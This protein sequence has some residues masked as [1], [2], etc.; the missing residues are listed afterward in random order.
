MHKS[1]TLS[2]TDNI[3]LNLYQYGEENC[4]KG[5][6]F[7]PAVRQHYLFHYV[8][9]GTG[10]LHSEYGAFPVVAGEGFLIHPH[11]VTTYCADKKDPW[12]YMWLEV[13]GLMAGKLFEECRLSR[14]FPIYRARTSDETPQALR[15]LRRL[16]THDDEHRLKTLGLSYLFFSA[17]IDHRLQGSDEH[18]SDKAQH[19]HKA[20][21]LIENRY[22]EQ[23]T[24]ER[25]AAYCN[26]NR[27]YLCRLFKGAYGIG[28]K[29]YLLNFRMTLATS[30]LRNS[31]TAIK[32]VGISVG[33]E[34]QLHFSKAFKQV[35]GVSPAKWRQ[36]NCPL[37]PVDAE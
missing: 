10:V 18:S 23:L 17:L 30:L 34:N 14:Q 25:L 26:I 8:I 20:V 24:I 7:G 37:T 35:H 21:K 1:F 28:P 33:Y 31:Q 13:D 22:H 5:H 2:R 11:D 32:V 15:Y 29:E 3:E 16:V 6:S 9:S 4:D 36:E 12:H 19:L 27:S